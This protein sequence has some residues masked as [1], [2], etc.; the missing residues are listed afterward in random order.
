LEKFQP[1]G[2]GFSYRGLFTVPEISDLNASCEVK[3]EGTEHQLK[4][5]SGTSSLGN[6][7][8]RANAK[9]SA[10]G[11]LVSG[12][13]N[14]EIEL[15][16]SGVKTI[17]PYLALAAGKYSENPSSRWKVSSEKLKNGREWTKISPY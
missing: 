10:R 13:S 16:E 7:K 6:F 3:I 8:G 9:I 1:Q 15:S 11:V 4:N 17:A 2:G 5:C 12:A 14:F